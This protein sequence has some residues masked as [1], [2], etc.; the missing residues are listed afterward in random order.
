MF[1]HIVTGQQQCGVWKND[2]C[3]SAIMSDI[4]WR[5]SAIRPTPYPIPRVYFIIISSRY[6]TTMLHTIY[7]L[8][9]SVGRSSWR[10]LLKM[11]TLLTKAAIG[12]WRTFPTSLLARG[13]K[14]AYWRTYACPETRVPAYT[15]SSKQTSLAFAVDR[16]HR[17]DRHY[18]RDL[19][20]QKCLLLY[21]LYI[22]ILI[23]VRI[24]H[25]HAFHRNYVQ[26]NCRFQ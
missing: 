8:L 4:Y 14:S 10:R 25:L 16:E 19:F 6:A 1:Y 20:R 15:Q 5:Q 17:A 21:I 9:C 26:L 23:A 24:N 13:H 7:R 18:L 12:P 11:P 22:Y 3:I 2:L